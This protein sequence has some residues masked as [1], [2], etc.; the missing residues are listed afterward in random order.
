MPRRCSVCL[1]KKRNE[2]D[3]ALAD[4]NL[5]LRV[6]SKRFEISDSALFRHKAS[7]IA[8]G[9]Q[10]LRAGHAEVVS[11]QE[12][13]SAETFRNAVAEQ[14]KQGSLLSAITVEAE[15]AKCFERMNKIFDA[16]DLFLEDPDNPGS[17]TLDPRGSEV[18]IIWEELEDEP[19]EGQKARWVRKTGTLQQALAVAFS[20]G[21][22]RHVSTQP[23]R[24]ADPRE[25]LLKIA[26]QLTTQIDLLAKL[27][28]RYRPVEKEL[29]QGDTI[30]MSLIVNILNAQGFKL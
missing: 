16:V 4:P 30:Q 29:N 8:K 1:H 9:F 14:T 19:I 18:R 15:T 24:Q 28:G 2:I 10:M 13:Q 22:R 25:L 5:S 26:A 6:L 7:C 21:H 20:N 3:A 12:A 17:Y 27:E 23:I 11:Q